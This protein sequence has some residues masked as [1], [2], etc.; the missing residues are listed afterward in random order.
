MAEQA[1]LLTP[2]PPV[3]KA[4][5]SAPVGTSGGSPKPSPE[6]VLDMTVTASDETVIT[7]SSTVEEA[8][9]SITG[10]Q[11]A[12]YISF[13]LSF[14]LAGFAAVVLFKKAMKSTERRLSLSAKCLG[15]VFAWT[16]VNLFFATY[17]YAN[18]L[19]GK[20]DSAPLTWMIALWVIGGPL[21]GVVLNYLLAPN[22]EAEKGRIIFDA[23]AFA[24][25]F[26]VT[27]VALIEGLKENALLIFS[28]CA[29]FLYIVPIARFLSLF[30]VAKARH[31][32]LNAGM[33]QVLV[34]ALLII[35]GLFPVLALARVFGLS[36]DAFIFCANFLT[37]D[38]ILIVATSM[39]YLLSDEST[40]IEEE[41]SV[42]QFGDASLPRNSIAAKPTPATSPSVRLPEHGLK[43]KKL[44]PGH[45]AKKPAVSESN[46]GLPSAPK[47]PN[48]ST[49]SEQSAPNAPSR[50]KAPAKPKKRF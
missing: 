1:S 12:I 5:G 13:V 3:G 44:T 9:N 8:G 2:I 26:I 21:I 7:A 40:E 42:A 49:N 36:V 30:K 35:P 50:I 23:A 43:P 14:C 45:A 4:G 25:I 19:S 18:F 47:K 10:F 41:S 6:K 33:A 48:K 28:L 11:G 46:E 20:S 16:S 24:L 31:A 22:E 29:L 38:F 17:L 34:Y 15:G 27:L 39:I 37:F 32:E